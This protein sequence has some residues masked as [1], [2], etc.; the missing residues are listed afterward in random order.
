M[1]P[2]LGSVVGTRC[3]FLLLTGTV[4]LETV[5]GINLK[6]LVDEAVVPEI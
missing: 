2:G 4:V 6:L 5:E 1:P 3:P